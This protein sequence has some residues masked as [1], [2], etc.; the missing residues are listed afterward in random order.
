MTNDDCVLIQ[1]LGCHRE[2]PVRPSAEQA[3][4]LLL[5]PLQGTGDSAKVMTIQF[6]QYYSNSPLFSVFTGLHQISP[7]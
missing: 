4:K 2:L 7:L 1:S 3:V 6:L 5:Q